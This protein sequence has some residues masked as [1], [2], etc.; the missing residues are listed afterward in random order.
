MFCNTQ[1]QGWKNCG[2][3]VTWM[4]KFVQW[5]QTY[6]GPHY[7]TCVISPCWL[8]EFEVASRFL[9]N[10]YPPT[11]DW[12][13]IWTFNF[14]HLCLVA[15]LHLKPLPVYLEF[16]KNVVLGVNVTIPMVLTV[17]VTLCGS[18]TYSCHFVRNGCNVGCWNLINNFSFRSAILGEVQTRGSTKLPSYKSVVV[19]GEC[20]YY[21][22]LCFTS[23][24]M[25]GG[26]WVQNTVKAQLI[27]CVTITEVETSCKLWPIEMNVLSWCEMTSLSMESSAAG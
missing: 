4:T 26:R 24:F 7:G 3:Q 20:L 8:L 27:C 2:H 16:N 11:L 1:V 10:L 25:F 19:L 21:F 14:Q 6:V 23:T 17:Y 13:W 18:G 15:Q 22:L 5:H 12:L 9:E